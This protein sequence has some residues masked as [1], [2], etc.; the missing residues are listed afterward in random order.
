[1]GAGAAAP[2]GTYNVNV[3]ASVGTSSQSVSPNIYSTVQSVTMD[4]TTQ[5]LDLNTNNGTVAMSAV[6]NV[7]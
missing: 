1:M 3:N 5:A 4:P 7:Q 2:A 6:L